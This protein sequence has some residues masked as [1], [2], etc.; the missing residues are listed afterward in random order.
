LSRATHAAFSW[1]VTFDNVAV[2]K[3]I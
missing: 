2:T 3:C 1:I